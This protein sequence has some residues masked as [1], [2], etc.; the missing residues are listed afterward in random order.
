M[1]QHQQQQ[2]QQA[3]GGQGPGDQGG[4]GGTDNQPSANGGPDLTTMANAMGMLNGLQGTSK[5]AMMKQ[6]SKTRRTL[7]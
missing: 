3:I 7:I 4:A 2:Q 5:E 1:I 6:V